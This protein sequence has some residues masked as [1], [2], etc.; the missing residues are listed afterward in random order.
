MPSKE[1]LIIDLQKS[2]IPK[3][4]GKTPK[5]KQY[6]KQFQM[7][8]ETSISKTMGRKYSAEIGSK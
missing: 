5:Y 2:D 3:H 8:H 1:K 6:S 4:S 7:F